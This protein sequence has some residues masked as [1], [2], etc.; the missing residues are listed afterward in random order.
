MSTAVLLT[1]GVFVRAAFD[2]AL[3]LIGLALPFVLIGI[4]SN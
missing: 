3:V 2:L 1:V 4:L